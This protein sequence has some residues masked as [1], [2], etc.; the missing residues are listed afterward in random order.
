MVGLS[1]VLVRGVPEVLECLF[2]DYGRPKMFEYFVQSWKPLPGRGGPRNIKQDTTDQDP[3]AL[4]KQA[5]RLMTIFERTTVWD[6]MTEGLGLE[7][8]GD[9]LLIQSWLTGR[10]RCDNK[11]YQ[12]RVDTCVNEMFELTRKFG[13]RP[14]NVGKDIFTHEY[15]EA[16]T[17]ADE[18]T[19]LAREGRTFYRNYVHFRS[20]EE[21]L[22]IPIAYRGAYDGGVCGKGSA[23]GFWLQA[24]YLDT[25]PYHSYLHTCSSSSSSHASCLHHHQLHHH[26][27]ESPLVWRDVAESAWLLAETA[28]ITDCELAAAEALARAVRLDLVSLEG[29]RRAELTP[30]R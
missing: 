18:L 15:R 13:V 5:K 1:L 3:K 16:N 28:T 30:V 24:G 11:I 21:G 10:W 2:A 9:S 22:L 27:H 25:T 6:V 17:R 29:P 14:A 20:Y 4:D 12:Q 23:C 7:I 19:H 8:R 26:A